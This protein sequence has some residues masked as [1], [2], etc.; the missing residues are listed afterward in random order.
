MIKLLDCTLRDGGYV[1]NWNFGKNCIE[2]FVDNLAE[3]GIDI[4]ELGFIRN[5][6]YSPERSIFTAA[7]NLSRFR[8]KKNMLYSAMIEGNDVDRNFP[9]EKLGKSSETG[10]DLIRVCTWK[11]LMKEH[12]DYCRLIGIGGYKISVQPTAVDQYSDEEFLQ[13]IDL[14]NRIKPFAFYI[15]DTWGTQSA[16]D[17]CHY[18]KIADE[19]LFPKTMLGYHGHNNKKQ[20]LSCVEALIKM[21][22]SRDLCVDGS[23]CGMGR[24]PGNLQTEVL[25]DF[26]NRNHDGKYNLLP[27]I[28]LYSKYVK[29]IS[30]RTS[31]GYSIYHFISSNCA[32]PQDFATY[33]REHNYT[34]EDFIRFV[35]SLSRSEKVT[36]RKDFVDRRIIELGICK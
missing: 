5:E 35:D 17:I 24:G 18:A 22:M 32:L 34:V 9:V 31:W 12:I 33:F 10:I 8:K 1:N 3:S 20:A 4:I 16:I 36:F 13:L 7:E 25:I 15:V 30:N 26:L 29:A 11:R 23:V 14:S 6:E 27:I 21:N 2:D 28:E 19:N